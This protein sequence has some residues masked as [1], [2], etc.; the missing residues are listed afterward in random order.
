M[1]SIDVLK[2]NLH[3]FE[4]N[5]GYV[6]KDKKNLILALTHSSYANEN[7]EL[8]LQSN[9]RIEFLGDSVLG[10]SVSEKIYKKYSN[11][12]EG[13]LTK[14]RA[15]VVCESSLLI[16]S[17]NIEI[18]KFILLGR[19]EE[20]TGGRKRSSL[21]S[22]AFEAVIG[23]IYID[24]GLEDAKNFVYRHMDSLIDDCAKGAIA[25]DYKTQL[26]ESIQKKGDKR[27]SY[28]IVSEK[29]PDHDKHFVAAVKL[30]DEII[31]T[32]KGKSKKEAE[33]NAAKTALEKK[34]G[35]E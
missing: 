4:A 12:S 35:F 34:W 25:M 23:A 29:G 18:Y 17:N 9:E 2:E 20:L 3:L 19:G 1:K 8:K 26:Q 15:N 21:L 16:C 14:V 11:L 30:G 27:L 24:S 31:G 28:E 7:K 13:E 10:I 6:F 22:D 32:G 5:I 33:Q